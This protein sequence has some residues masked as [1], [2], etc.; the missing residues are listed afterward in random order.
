MEENVPLLPQGG[1][2]FESMPKSGIARSSVRTISS[3]LMNH[4]IDF[5]SGCTSLQSHQQWRNVHLSPYPHPPCADIWI[6]NLASL[7]GVRENIRILL[8][9][10][11][12]M[13]EDFEHLFKYF[14]AIW[15]YSVM[16]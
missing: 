5:Q 3:F 4:Y 6:L 8:I 2:S 10:I 12:L 14:L 13:T 1:E 15:D 9:L 16:N 11:S 7:I